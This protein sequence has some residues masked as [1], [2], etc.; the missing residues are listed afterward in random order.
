MKGRNTQSDQ[1]ENVNMNKLNDEQV[2]M[3]ITSNFVLISTI[4]HECLAVLKSTIMALYSMLY[5]VSN[6]TV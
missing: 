5:V 4:L 1:G 2:Y 3:Y 6:S